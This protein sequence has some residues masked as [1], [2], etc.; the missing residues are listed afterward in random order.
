MYR[1]GTRYLLDYLDF[2]HVVQSI[3]F[4]FDTI[5]AV[6]LHIPAGKYIVAV[7]GGV[8]SMA[9][10][11]ALRACPGL[12]LVVAHFDHGIRPD[13]A[14][15][16]KLVAA[17]AKE[18]G[19]PYMYKTAKLGPMCSEATAREARY[20][21]LRKARQEQGA[22]AIITAHHQDDM[23][24]TAIINLLR[25]TNRKGLSAL[26]SGG[27]L[28]RPLLDY[29][30]KDLLRYA[31]E[32]NLRWHEDSTNADERYLRNYVRRN[33]LTRF[34]EAGK[35]ALLEKVRQARKIND[36][37]DTLL[38]RDLDLQPALDT[39]KRKWYVQLP[40][41]VASEMMA[42]WLRRNG[43]ISFDRV[44]IDRLVIAAKTARPGKRAD[45][46]AAYV[47]EIERDNLKITVR[48]RS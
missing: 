48:K 34:G 6:E 12:E 9:L 14:Q 41:A 27:E 20:A 40:H 26:A 7:S 18:Y 13:S 45:V 47:L 29:S 42:T 4:A 30:K 25:G 31:R 24:E 46:N 11:H 1:G 43:I 16:R 15:D 44:L 2:G 23:L 36:Q 37:T 33:I 22:A 28:L 8:D 5:I 17:A 32:H 39:L 21:F 3:A 38:N 10:L 19:L 35:A